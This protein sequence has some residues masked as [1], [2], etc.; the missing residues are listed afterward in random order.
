MG[1]LEN[2][3]KNVNKGSGTQN[4]TQNQIAEQHNHYSQNTSIPHNLTKI[5]TALSNTNVVED[6]NDSSFSTFEIEKK[7]THNNLSTNRYMI[8][9]YALYETQIQGIYNVLESDGSLKKNKILGSIK[10]T[11]KR[12]LTNYMKNENISQAYAITNK[13]DFI[14]DDVA[15]ELE[16]AIKNADSSISEDDVVFGVRVVIANAFMACKIFENPNI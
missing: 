12:I 4:I 7:I 1:D 10:A 14:I 9:D 16:S 6:S 8:D 3:S 15:K 5:I 11:Y 13:A 2:N